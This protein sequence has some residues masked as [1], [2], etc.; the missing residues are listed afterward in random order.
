MKV[1]KFISLI[2]LVLA[3][4]SCDNDDNYI[5]KTEVSL[6]MQLEDES[7]SISLEAIP[8]TFTN[9]NNGTI[10]NTVSDANGKVVITIE[11]GVYNIVANGEKTINEQ[12]IVVSGTQENVVINSTSATIQLDLFYTVPGEGWVI[13]EVYYA[14]TRTPENKVYYKDQY[15]EIYNNSNK[16]LYADGLSISEAQHNTSKSVNEWSAYLEQG[17]VV[18]TI[19]TIPGSGQEHPVQPGESLI[20]AS[21]PLDHT[22]ENDNSIDLS[23]ADWQW[24]DEGTTDVNVAEVPNLIKHY[25]YS[26]TFWLLH[27]SGYNSFVLFRAEDINA[28]LSNQRV[29]TENTA[30]NIIEG[31]LVSKDLILDAVET[32]RKDKFLTKALPASLD[33]SYTFCDATFS[34]KCIRR[35][36]QGYDGD[37]AVLADTNN[38]DNDFIKNADLKPGQVE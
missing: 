12:T 29:E 4:F 18:R 33:L 22:T 1:F 15:I 19:Y 8:L 30:G 37:R 2:T 21:Q 7:L 10:Y 16:V 5:A 25:S 11:D 38:S 35:K 3:L 34:G 27:T 31:Y 24:F 14:G 36:V 20:L 23:K 17:V 13:K 9:I 6:S 32:S 28:F 26:K